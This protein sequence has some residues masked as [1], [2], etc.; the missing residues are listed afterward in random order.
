MKEPIQ[1]F[2]CKGDLEANWIAELCA[3]Q[4]AEYAA[5]Q[6]ETDL[7]YALDDQMTLHSRESEMCGARASTDAHWP[8]RELEPFE[9]CAPDLALVGCELVPY[10]LEASL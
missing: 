5:W 6:A 3:E 9:E 4:E 2:V 7:A 1:I 10:H 8:P